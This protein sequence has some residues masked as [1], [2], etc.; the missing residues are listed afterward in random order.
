[1]PSKT[2]SLRRSQWVGVALAEGSVAAVAV[3]WAVAQEAAAA[4]G[5][6]A[7]MLPG[8]AVVCRL[9]GLAADSADLHA[10]AAP[11]VSV[12]GVAINH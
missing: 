4:V 11:G 3:A 2:R 12:V 9:M 1:M 10:T 7:Q 6:E 5:V 8:E